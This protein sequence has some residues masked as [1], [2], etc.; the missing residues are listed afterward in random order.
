MNE[1]DSLRYAMVIASATVMSVGTYFIYLATRT[2]ELDAKRV[3]EAFIAEHTGGRPQ[4][5]P[6]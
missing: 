1:G 4:E 5:P 3:L 6:T 2:A